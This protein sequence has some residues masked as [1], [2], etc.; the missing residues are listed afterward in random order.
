MDVE[1]LPASRTEVQTKDEIG[2]RKDGV[3][4]SKTVIIF[5]VEIILKYSMQLIIA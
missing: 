4:S 1:C 2:C 3:S 5:Q